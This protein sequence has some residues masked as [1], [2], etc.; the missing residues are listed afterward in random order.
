MLVSIPLKYSMSE[1]VGY[2]KGKSAIEIT[3]R[4]RKVRKITGE[5][6]WARDYFVSTVGMGEREIRLYIR[7]Q[8]KED[9]RVE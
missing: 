7:N 5:S 4:F 8:E 9:R 2:L 3:R 6:F 1:I